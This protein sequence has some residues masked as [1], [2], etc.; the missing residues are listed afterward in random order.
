MCIED[1]G[2]VQVHI[3]ENFCSKG[4]QTLLSLLGTMENSFS[5][6]FKHYN[7]II[8]AINFCVTYF[9]CSPSSLGQDPTIES[10]KR[11]L[12]F[13]FGLLKIEMANLR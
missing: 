3:V 8:R 2:E 11:I 5:F 4:S 13:S 6:Q 10:A 1:G 7:L 9:T 12:F